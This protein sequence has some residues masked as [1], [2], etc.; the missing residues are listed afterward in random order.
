MIRWGYVNCGC[1]DKGLHKGNNTNRLLV[2]KGSARWQ[3]RRHQRKSGGGADI[4]GM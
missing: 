2:L 1:T 3:G 4:Y